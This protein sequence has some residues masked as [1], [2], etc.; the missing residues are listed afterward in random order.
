[1]EISKKIPFCQCAL[2]PEFAERYNVTEENGKFMN[3][4]FCIQ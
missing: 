4:V 2:T 3:V 1:M